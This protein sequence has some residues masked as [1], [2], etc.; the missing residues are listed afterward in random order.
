MRQQ[1]VWE[2]FIHLPRDRKKREKGDLEPGVL[3]NG[4]TLCD[5]LPSSKTYIL[6]SG[7]LKTCTTGCMIPWL[8]WIS[9]CPH[10]LSSEMAVDIPSFWN[11][12]HC[13]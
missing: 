8:P 6:V 7:P 2:E 10:C 9:M 11:Y 13:K 3:C 12:W 4:E 1:G 5:L